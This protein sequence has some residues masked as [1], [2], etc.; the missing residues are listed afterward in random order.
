MKVP[1]LRSGY[2]SVGGVC[3]FGRMLDKIRLHGAGRLPAEYVT[4]L[5]DKEPRFGDGRCTRFLQVNYDRLV[6]RVLAGGSDEEI[7]EWCF[8]EGR[9]PTDEEIQNWNGFIAKLGWR[10]DTSQRFAAAKQ[11]LG[12]GDR[13]DVNTWLDLQDA[14]EQR[15]PRFAPAPP[16]VEGGPATASENHLDPC[17]GKV[18]GTDFVMYQVSDLATAAR[19]YRE[20]LGLPQEVYSEEW[21]WAEFNCGNVTLA[22]HGGVKLPDQIAG[23]RIALAV[24]DVHAA[25]AE[26]KRKGARVVG[27]PV[28]YS[29][30]C[31][32]EVLDPDGN[33]VIL[34]QRADGTCGQD[35]KNT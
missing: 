26:L 11:S 6:Q 22:L 28:D 23:G 7:L 13:A 15:P 32:V 25:C 4:N 16:R 18:R 2:E 33:T 20:T 10:D 12:L 17:Q 29:V 9:R 3:F 5:G 21:H 31:A 30:C 1:G 19:F 24:D 35:S 8:A 27:E 34:H 14:D